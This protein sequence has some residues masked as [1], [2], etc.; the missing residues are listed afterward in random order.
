MKLVN[1]RKLS[2]DP[3]EKFVYAVKF[4]NDDVNVIDYFGDFATLIGKLR[5]KKFDMATGEWIITQNGYESFERLD[6][7]IFNPVELPA[8]SF[9]NV[10]K[11]IITNWFK[12]S[13]L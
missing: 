10:E 4:N 11:K 12:T 6:D 8:V 2:D 3:N 13:A 1:A 5:S 7:K 9:D